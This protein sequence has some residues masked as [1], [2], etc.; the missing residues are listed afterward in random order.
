MWRVVVR[1]IVKYRIAWFTAK[2]TGVT[3]SERDINQWK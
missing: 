1:L 3:L 2:P